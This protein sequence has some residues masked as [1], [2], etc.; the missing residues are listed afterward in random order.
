MILIF[1]KNLQNRKNQSEKEK[2]P[3]IFKMQL[4]LEG[5]KI[6]MLLNVEYFQKENK[7]KDFQVF[8]I[9]QLRSRTINSPKY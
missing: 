1:L 5:K 8:W 6:L 9:T 7:E 3:L 2:K 4:Y